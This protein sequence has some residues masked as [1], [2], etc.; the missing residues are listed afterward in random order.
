M[1]DSSFTFTSFATPQCHAAKVL[2]TLQLDE[3]LQIYIQA[4]TNQQLEDLDSYIHHLVL[5]RIPLRN[6]KNGAHR[7]LIFCRVNDFFSDE[8]ILSSYQAVLEAVFGP[9]TRAHAR[10][11]KKGGTYG[12]C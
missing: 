5:C 4:A 7:Q 6:R 9:S 1:K 2:T 11:Y 10:I 8:C 3:V 12:S